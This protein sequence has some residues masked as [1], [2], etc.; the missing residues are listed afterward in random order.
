M[1]YVKRKTR[2]SLQISIE[3][4]KIHKPNHKSGNEN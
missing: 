3:I 4:E 1:H 2:L